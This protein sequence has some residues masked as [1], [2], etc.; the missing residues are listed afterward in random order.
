MENWNCLKVK[1][2]AFYEIEENI[3]SVDL[4]GFC[5]SYNQIYCTVVYLRIKATFGIRISLLVSKTK[6]SSLKKLSMPCLELLS[7]FLLSKLL[8]EVLS[9]VTKRIYVNNICC[10]S[11]FEAAL[12]WINGKGKSWRPWVEN[13]VVNMKKVADRD[14]WFHVEGVH[15]PADIPTRVVSCEESL[16]KWFDG[17]EILYKENIMSVEFDAGKNLK[18]VDEM[19]NPWPTVGHG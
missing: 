19:V 11:N 9:I 12:R 10:W 15:N 14:N 16:R 8:N 5:N 4:H 7:C 1:R 17:P 6:V 2:F 3:L 18:L 13:R